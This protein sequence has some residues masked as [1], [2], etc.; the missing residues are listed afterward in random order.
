MDPKIVLAIAAHPDDLEFSCGGSV[1]KF[2]KKGAEVYYVILTDGSK[3]SEDFKLPS[4]KLIKMRQH[5]QQQAAETLGVK[6]VYFFDFIDGELENTH[7]VKKSLVKLIRELK[8]DTVIAF[9]PTYVYNCE[10]GM[11]N[12]PDHRIS[13]QIA[14]DSIFPFSRNNRTYPELIEE[15][16]LESHIVKNVLLINLTQANFFIDISETIDQKIDAIKKHC[17]QYNDLKDVEN[18]MRGR[19]EELGKKAGF[20]KAEG[21]VRIEI[22]R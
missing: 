4:E 7:D 9:D 3:G 8:P 12:H 15:H 16:G 18:R 17:S 20:K 21:F 22:A 19:A 6:R 11:I 10:T 14:L 5:E 2:V 13:G 1:A